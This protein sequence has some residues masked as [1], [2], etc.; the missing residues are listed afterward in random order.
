MKIDKPIAVGFVQRLLP[1]YRLGF[2]KALSKLNTNYKFTILTRQSPDSITNIKTISKQEFEQVTESETFNWI[3]TKT[4]FFYKI[5]ILW[6]RS[7]LFSIF[8]KKYDIVLITNNMTHIFYWI[9]ILCCKLRNINVVY[10]SHGLQ[11][12]ECG[13][14]LKL[15]TIYL[16]LADINLVYARYNKELMINVGMNANK[17]FV[18][19]NSL[20]LSEID[21]NINRH[22]EEKL[23]AVK[24]K[25]FDN[26]FPTL[27]FI[28]RLEKS[29]KI[30]QLLQA[31]KLLKDRGVNVN[32]LI[33]GNGSELGYL[34][35]TSQLLGLEES[36]YFEKATY[37]ESQL[38]AFFAISDIFVSP[39]NV[40]LN[41]IHSLA[42]GLPVITHSDFRYQNPEVEAI[43][44]NKTGALF[45]KDDI[46]DL[47]DT[48][49][50]WINNQSK[51]LSFLLAREIVQDL[52]SPENQASVV[53][54]ALSSLSRHR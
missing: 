5:Y 52:Y 30:E 49:D 14:K 3:D 12:N 33:V 51:E 15:K 22:S 2:Y 13:F 43:V 38:S 21:K 35:D 39:G 32:V 47:A 40:G 23:L 24:K 1:Y 36:V 27:L 16:K 53:L 4:L 42:Y 10:W 45:K 9:V 48:I 26:D 34:M 11:G 20:D 8:L 17:I 25:Y 41:C 54:S 50:N 28:S 6:Q 37:L 29:K 18:M 44:V 19:Y 7:I 46:K 31:A